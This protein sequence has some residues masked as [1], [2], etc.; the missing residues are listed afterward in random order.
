MSNLNNKI[1]LHILK[2][3]LRKSITVSLT[4]FQVHET[5]LPD[6]D[7]SRGNTNRERKEEINNLGFINVLSFTLNDTAPLF[8][9]HLGPGH[10]EVG[11]GEEGK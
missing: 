1:S 8:P 6:S 10:K 4:L 9:A 11:I 7:A 3:F 2:V 5:L